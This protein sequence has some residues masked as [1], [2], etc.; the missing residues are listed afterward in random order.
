MKLKIRVTKEILKRSMMCGVGDMLDYRKHCG[1]AE[2]VRDIFPNAEIGLSTL[3]F[4][5]SFPYLYA[6][7]PDNA[8]HWRQDF[9]NLHKTPKQR[10]NLP[11]IEFEVFLSDGVIDA[12]PINIDE[13]IKIINQSETLELA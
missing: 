13:A 2:A 11:E 1:I 3:T 10:L 12:L 9:D 5:S 7:L 8:I 4:D 6:I